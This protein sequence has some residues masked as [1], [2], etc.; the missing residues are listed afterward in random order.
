MV[1]PEGTSKYHID[2]AWEIAENTHKGHTRRDGKTPY[3]N[4]IKGVV[5]NLEAMGCE[6][7]RIILP[8][9]LHDAVEDSDDDSRPLLMQKINDAFGDDVLKIVMKV[10]HMEGS[11]DDYIYKMVNDKDKA[12]AIIKI[13]DIIDN[14]CDDPTPNQVKKY[15]KALLLL[16]RTAYVQ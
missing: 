16:I 13:A 12:P 14:L 3:I 7:L 2:R 15:R 1:V 9:I 5:L 8:A 10:S 6:S 4:H 11:Y